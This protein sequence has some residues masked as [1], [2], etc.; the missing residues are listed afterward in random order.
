M[1]ISQLKWTFIDFIILIFFIKWIIISIWVNQWVDCN[2][3]SEPK[4]EPKSTKS[5]AF[6]LATDFQ[7]TKTEKRQ[8][9]I[10]RKLKPKK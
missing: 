2:E 6:L 1:S 5:V 10:N 9:R 7:Y 3:M 4:L 8:N